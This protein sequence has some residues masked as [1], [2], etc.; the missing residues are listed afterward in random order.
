MD[1]LSALDWRN[2]PPASSM[3]NLACNSEPQVPPNEQNDQ[4]TQFSI[5]LNSVS[6]GGIAI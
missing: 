3:E 1:T 6:M 4:N 2:I 5:C